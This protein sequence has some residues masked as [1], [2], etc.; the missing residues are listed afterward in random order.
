MLTSMR[1]LATAT[2][3]RRVGSF[4]PGGFAAWFSTSQTFEFRTGS[5]DEVTQAIQGDKVVVFSKTYCPFCTRAKALLAEEYEQPISI[6][7]LDV[8]P[9]GSEIQASL[10]EITGQSTVP[11]VF[12]GGNHIGGH[13]D[14]V[15][16]LES[17]ELSTA[18]EQVANQ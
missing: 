7:E 4:L 9:N 8:H 14:V 6:Y 11:N 17:G 2:S 12:V 16:G 5:V 10:A 1:R 3:A 15:A 18:L 13:D